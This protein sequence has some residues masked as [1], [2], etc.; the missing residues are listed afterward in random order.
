MTKQQTLVYD[1]TTKRMCEMPM[2]DN[3]KTV[4][5]NW[6]HT[7]FWVYTID[8]TNTFEYVSKNVSTYEVPTIQNGYNYIK[9]ESFQYITTDKY[10]YNVYKYTY[11]YKDNTTLTLYKFYL[12]DAEEDFWN[13]IYELKID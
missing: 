5:F 3:Y 8:E 4:S 2:S 13:G 6:C 11:E 7:Y 9:G 10:Y 12:L 1:F